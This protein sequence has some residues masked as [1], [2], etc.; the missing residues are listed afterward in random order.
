V[1][2]LYLMRRN[3]S[4]AVAGELFGCSQA[5]VSRTVRRPRPLLRQALAAFTGQIRVQAQSSAVLV[6][7]F[8][9]PTGERTGVEGMYSGKRHAAGFNVQAVA[10]LDSRLVDTGLPLCLPKMSSA[11]VKRS[12]SVLVIG[13]GRSHASLSSIDA[14]D[15]AMMPRHAASTGVPRCHE[16]VRAA[17]PA[18]S[19]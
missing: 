12:F 1:L 10:D 13:R 14:G 6:D 15:C 2:T 5:T 9:A 16:R 17:T 18:A 7:G 3:E 11:L 4:Q 8:L 19:Q